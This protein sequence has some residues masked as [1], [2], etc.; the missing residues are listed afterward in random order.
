MGYQA[1]LTALT[2][3]GFGRRRSRFLIRSAVELAT[4]ARDRF[5]A[6]HSLAPD[7]RPLVAASHGP[8]GA[9]L[10]NGFEY[11]GRYGVE[12]ERL[13][14]F[15]AP[16]FEILATSSADVIAC[17]TVPSLMEAEVLCQII[18][19]TPGTKAWISF[20]CRDDRRLSD[21]TPI[22]E[23]ANTCDGTAGMVALGVNCVNPATV[24]AL[25]SR[26]CLAT[27]LPV[28]AYPNA[29]TGFGAE[30]YGRQSRSEVYGRQSVETRINGCAELAP[31]WI[32]AGAQAIGGCCGVGPMELAAIAGALGR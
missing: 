13:R 27:D 29:G 12:A 6:E 8:F 10:P 31:R 7:R 28:I 30:A 4:E 16:T 9:Y 21:G 18:G 25:V 20:V 17:E 2:E 11:D 5:A 1:S 14:D 32:D 24:E 19:E 3:A 22:E 23:A 26:L 15:H